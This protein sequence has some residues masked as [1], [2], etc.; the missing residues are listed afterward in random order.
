MIADKFGMSVYGTVL[1]MS[2]ILYIVPSLVCEYCVC[3]HMQTFV[4]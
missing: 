3:F 2:F 4:K 1:L